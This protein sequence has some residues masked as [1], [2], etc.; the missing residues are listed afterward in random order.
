MSLGWVTSESRSRAGSP[1]PLPGPCRAVLPLVRHLVA[2]PNARVE[3]GL[4]LAVALP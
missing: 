3:T 1:A 4:L 2:G